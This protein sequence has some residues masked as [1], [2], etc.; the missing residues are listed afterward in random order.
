MHIADEGTRAIN[1]ERPPQNAVPNDDQSR[2]L[3]ELIIQNDMLTQMLS[4]QEEQA[5][6]ARRSAKYLKSINQILCFYLII[7]I[8]SSIVMY[9]WLR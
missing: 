8:I 5:E 4:L 2:A 7:D 3:S 9:F 6:E 1:I